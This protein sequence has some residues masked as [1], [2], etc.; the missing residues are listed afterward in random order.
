VI[1]QQLGYRNFA[2]F[3]NEYRVG[4]AK[5]ALRDPAQARRQVL[6]IALDLGYGSIAPFNRAFRAAT[7]VTPTAFRRDALSDGLDAANAAAE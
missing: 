5:E 4:A 3:L 2:A 6:Q 7:G 1:N